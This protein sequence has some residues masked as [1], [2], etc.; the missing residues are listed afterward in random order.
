MPYLS[1][2]FKKFYY[3]IILRWNLKKYKNIINTNQFNLIYPDPEA[4]TNNQIYLGFDRELTRKMSITGKAIFFASEYKYQA[5]FYE[6]FLIG[7][8]LKYEL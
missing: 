8:G 4:N 5:D 7:V 1:A 6:K 2:G 3:Q